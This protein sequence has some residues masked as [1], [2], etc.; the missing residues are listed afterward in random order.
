MNKI[1]YH[2]NILRKHLNIIDYLVIPRQE[3]ERKIL[4]AIL[5]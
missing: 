3:Q 4:E 2:N 1:K 5:S